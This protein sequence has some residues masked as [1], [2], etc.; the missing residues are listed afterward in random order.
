MLLYNNEY[1][2]YQ[3]PKWWKHLYRAQNALSTQQTFYSLNLSEVHVWPYRSE[4]V[5]FVDI[6]QVLDSICSVWSKAGLYVI[7]HH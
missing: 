4:N 1:M 3:G 2:S 6:I 7:C 5:D